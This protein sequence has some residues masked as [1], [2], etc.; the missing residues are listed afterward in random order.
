LEESVKITDNA[1]RISVTAAARVSGESERIPCFFYVQ[2]MSKAELM[3]SHNNRRYKSAGSK[4][5]NLLNFIL[6]LRAGTPPFFGILKRRGTFWHI[7]AAA[8]VT[9]LIL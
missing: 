9:L 2:K 7:M 6:L 5:Q 3:F 4:G 1:A 8:F